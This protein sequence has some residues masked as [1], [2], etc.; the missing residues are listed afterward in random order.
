MAASGSYVTAGGSSGTA[1]TAKAKAFTGACYN[2]GKI[3]H[4]KEQC[5]TK[6]SGKGKNKGKGNVQ[7]VMTSDLL[8]SGSSAISAGPS[9][10]TV[11]STA[12]RALSMTKDEIDEDQ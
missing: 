2:C 1:K 8:T 11:E 12:V 4:K 7:Q 5:W 3:G 6:D 9:A 10:S